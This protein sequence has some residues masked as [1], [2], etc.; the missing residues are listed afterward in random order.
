MHWASADAALAYGYGICNKIT[1]GRPYAQIE[2]ISRLIFR[3][4]MS[5]W[6]RM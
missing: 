3:H 1:E 5:L 4:L 2:A 6:R